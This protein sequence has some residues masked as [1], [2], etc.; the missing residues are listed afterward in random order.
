MAIY[1]KREREIKFDGLTAKETIEIGRI[2][3]IVG[4]VYSTVGL[5]RVDYKLRMKDIDGKLC[6]F[7]YDDKMLND[8]LSN[9]QIIRSKFYILPKNRTSFEPTNLVGYSVDGDIVLPDEMDI[10]NKYIYRLFKGMG[11]IDLNNSRVGFKVSKDKTYYM[12]VKR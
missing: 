8:W 11:L 3:L 10:M 5:P 12:I 1:R 6:D 2:V 4:I 9:S 7:Q